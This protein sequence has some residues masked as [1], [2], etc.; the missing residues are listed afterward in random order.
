MNQILCTDVNKNGKTIDVKTILIFFAISV[1]IFGIV[2]V[3][4]GS[5][6]FYQGALTSAEE[7]VDTKPQINVNQN[8]DNTL[9]IN[10]THETGIA[11][12][13]YA[14]NDEEETTI[15]GNNQVSVTSTIEIPGGTNTL[16]ITAT[17]V[18]GQSLLFEKSYTSDQGIQINLSVVDTS[19]QATITGEDEISFVTY[20]WDDETEETVE[21]NS[22]TGEVTIEIPEGQ[23]TLTIIA[24]DINNNTATKTQEVKGVTKP[25]LN[26]TQAG[27]NFTVSVSD[28]TGLEKVEFTL[29]GQAYL[30]RL[31]GATE[32]EFSYPL[33]DGE[34]TLEVTVYNTEGVTSTINVIYIK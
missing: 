34:N 26:V 31:E 2:L 16:K 21:I 27:E 11:N 28:E 1:L 20:R 29:N 9:T 15:E 23:H 10:A 3:T 12:I 17:A 19:L 5:Y 33:E 8:D 32:K 30:V 14:W 7:T 25:D 13:V 22:T 18:N 24:V 4:S 6:G